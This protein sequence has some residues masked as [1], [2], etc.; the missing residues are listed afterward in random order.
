MRDIS[1]NWLIVIESQLAP[2]SLLL[3]LR[4]SQMMSHRSKIWILVFKFYGNKNKFLLKQITLETCILSSI[5]FWGIYECPIW[6]LPEM[7]RQGQDGGL[8]SSG[9]RV[10]LSWHS[11]LQMGFWPSA[12]TPLSHTTTAKLSCSILA[13]AN[14][15][16]AATTHLPMDSCSP[17]T[18]STSPTYCRMLWLEE[19]TA[20]T[21]L[22]LACWPMA[23]GLTQAT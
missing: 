10:K 12:R 17:L 18:W 6:Q 3:S 14:G 9:R 20:A 22:K 13:P 16:R 5:N 15:W 7:I 21:C 2:S 11:K 8:H 23:H 4:M 19:T 1:D